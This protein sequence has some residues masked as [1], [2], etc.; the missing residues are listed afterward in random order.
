M[1]FLDNRNFLFEKKVNYLE[2]YFLEL[3]YHFL[4][5]SRKWFFKTVVKTMVLKNHFRLFCIL[6]SSFYYITLTK[7]HCSFLV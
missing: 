4:Q 2:M 7:N 1:H 5:N 6:Y 3:T